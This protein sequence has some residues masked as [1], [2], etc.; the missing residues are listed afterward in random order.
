MMQC[1]MPMQKVEIYFHSFYLLARYQLFA[2]SY[3]G[4]ITPKKSPRI[5][6]AT[7]TQE[8]NMHFVVMQVVP[9]SALM[10]MNVW[11]VPIFLL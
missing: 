1:T 10:D 3:V 6:V 2:S 4:N 11:Q 9:A 5:F 8:G 7:L